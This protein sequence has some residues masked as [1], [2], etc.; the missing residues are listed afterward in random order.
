MY[1][2]SIYDD[3]VNL[4]SNN[5]LSKNNLL[6]LLK[7]YAGSISVFDLMN[8]MAYSDSTF[9]GVYDQWKFLGSKIQVETFIQR[10]KKIKTD[11]NNYTGN[12]N[13]TELKEYLL[14]IKSIG[15]PYYELVENSYL[16]CMVAIVYANYIL[17]E[18]V[19]PEGTEFP[20]SVKVIKK[21][22]IYYCPAKEGNL[23]NSNAF[24]RLCIAEQLK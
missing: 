11:K 7:E 22:K 2:N 12:V 3:L 18:P 16:I 10:I 6:I 23:E 13:L 17:Q 19:H 9:E 4:N 21:D 15:E 20:G 24:C 8:F 1:I 5:V 14:K